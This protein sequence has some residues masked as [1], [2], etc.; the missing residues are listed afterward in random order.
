MA[1]IDMQG[2]SVTISDG[3]ATP[4]PVTIG[5]ITSVENDGGDVDDNDV[6]TLADTAKRF[7]PGLQDNGRSTF[8][9]FIDPA[10]VGQSECKS[11][12]AAAAVREFVVT[13]EDGSTK[14]FD[15]YVKSISDGGGVGGQR[16]GTL[17]IKVDGEIVDAAAP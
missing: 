5:G 15:A 16:Q 9:L 13:Y 4:S 2:A 10:D 1:I 6:T 17:T 14:T 12:R 3:A 8:N 7:R 11:A